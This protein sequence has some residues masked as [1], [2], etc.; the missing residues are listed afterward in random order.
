LIIKLQDYNFNHK[1][2]INY[3]ARKKIV[4]TNDKESI[5]RL[6]KEIKQKKYN[7]ATFV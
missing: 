5:G 3:S 2:K 1:T 4:F 7:S 6:W